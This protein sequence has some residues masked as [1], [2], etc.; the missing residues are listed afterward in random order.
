MSNRTL[1]TLQSVV[2]EYIGLP[3]SARGTYLAGLAINEQIDTMNSRDAWWLVTMANLT[4]V[5]GSR[6]YSLS[7]NWPNFKAHI[8]TAALSAD[9]TRRERYVLYLTQDD[10]N[11]AGYEAGLGLTGIPSYLSVNPFGDI[12]QIN[13]DPTAAY[14]GRILR[15]LYYR[16]L[17]RMSISTGTLGIDDSAEDLVVQGAIWRA[18]RLA[19]LDYDSD[20][21]NAEMAEKRLLATPQSV[22]LAS[23]GLT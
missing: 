23:M 14:N 16:K 20:K 10:Y 21:H 5:S 6:T 11:R 19:R 18:R 3:G 7:T 15:T 12:I 13:T 8:T 22:D 4:L 1:A 17:G 9:G 2:A